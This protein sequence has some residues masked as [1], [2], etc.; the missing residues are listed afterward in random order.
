MMCHKQLN[1]Y[2]Y[3]LIIRDVMEHEKKSSNSSKV[4]SFYI[5]ESLIKTL[6]NY[7][8]SKAEQFE[9]K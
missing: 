4:V 9:R 2:T 1:S 7:Q 3:F 8:Q 5:N 6:F